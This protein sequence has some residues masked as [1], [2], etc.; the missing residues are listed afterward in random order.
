[1]S[2]QQLARNRPHERGRCSVSQTHSRSQRAPERW[3]GPARQRTVSCR[4]SRA[5]PPRGGAVTPLQRGPRAASWLD[6]HRHARA[7]GQGELELIRDA[8]ICGAVVDRPCRYGLERTNG[9]GDRLS[10]SPVNR[11]E[12]ARNGEGDLILGEDAPGHPQHRDARDVVTQGIPADGRRCA[13]R[14]G[15]RDTLRVQ[16]GGGCDPAA[17]ECQGT[18]CGD[19]RHES[20]SC[21]NLLTR[22]EAARFP[23]RSAL[24]VLGCPA[25]VSSRPLT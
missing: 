14:G 9:C 13:C 7:A 3:G 1:M 18:H 25:A 4:N 11:H 10:V 20:V 17:H 15:D 8:K 19:H 6:I 2:N 21:H 12:P 16:H 22:S 5:D 24:L 23:N